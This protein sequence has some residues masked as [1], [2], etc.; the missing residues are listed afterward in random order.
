[1]MAEGLD[2]ILAVGSALYEPYEGST[3]ARTRL[4][5]PLLLVEEAGHSKASSGRRGGEVT[6]VTRGPWAGLRGWWRARRAFSF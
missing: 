4:E 1:M 3:R 5:R 6:F 2:G